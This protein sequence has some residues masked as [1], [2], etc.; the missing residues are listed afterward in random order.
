[1][2]R[3]NLEFE[4]VVNWTYYVSFSGKPPRIPAKATGRPGGGAEEE[5]SH[6]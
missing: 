4:G 5:V 2:S 3:R 1:M 6:I